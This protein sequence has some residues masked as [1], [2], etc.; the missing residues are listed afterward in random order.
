MTHARVQNPAR[1]WQEDGMSDEERPKVRRDA[2][3][4]ERLPRPID[5]DGLQALAL[6][7]AARYATTTL[8]LRRYLERKL[9]E[10]PWRGEAPADLETLVMKLAGLGYVNDAAW[11]EARARDMTARGLGRRRIVQTLAAAGVAGEGVDVEPETALAAAVHFARKRRLGPFAKPTRL[12]AA[13]VQRRAMAAML[14]AGHDFEVARR[15]LA[16]RSEAEAL[17]LE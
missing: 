14:R 17:A 6:H 4:R 3:P 16:A 5:A 9:R 13:V 1:S 15:V 2:N 11:G 10:R 7:Y 12:D 8:K